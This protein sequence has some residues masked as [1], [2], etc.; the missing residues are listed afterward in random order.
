MLQEP[1]C[2]LRVVILALRRLRDVR[3]ADAWQAVRS[4]WDG[5]VLVAAGV[6]FGAEAAAGSQSQALT[7]GQRA[8]A[9]TKRWVRLTSPLRCAH[10]NHSAQATAWLAS[11]DS[12]MTVCTL[13]S[14]CNILCTSLTRISHEAAGGARSDSLTA[15]VRVVTTGVHVS[16]AGHLSLQEEGLQARGIRAFLCDGGRRPHLLSPAAAAGGRQSCH[17]REGAPASGVYHWHSWHQLQESTPSAAHDS[18]SN[19]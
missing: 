9:A 11:A 10:Q 3:H 14:A 18:D 2:G 8:M 5:H 12:R 7:P 15:K 17:S 16:R 13:K 1:R 4:G 6:D 19:A